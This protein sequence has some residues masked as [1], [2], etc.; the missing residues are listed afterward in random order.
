MES[1]IAGFA[2]GGTTV[3]V[4]Q[5]LDTVKTILQTKKNESILSV[6]KKLYQTGGITAFYR[7]GVPLLLGGGLMRS[8]QFGFYKNT[9][10]LLRSNSSSSPEKVMGLDPHVVIAGFSGGIGRGMVEGPFEFLK[11]RRQIQTSW[12]YSDVLK[13]SGTTMVRNAFLFASFAIYMDFW[14]RF[15]LSE[16]VSSGIASFLKGG[17]CANM[18]WLTICEFCHQSIFVLYF[19]VVY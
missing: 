17:C 2:Y 1:F 19:I 3:V 15:K 14:D 6:S 9:L 13:G 7:G 12:N 10:Q 8:A 5:P 18:A 16:N 11:V 4:G